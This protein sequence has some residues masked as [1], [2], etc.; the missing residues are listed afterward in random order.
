MKKNYIYEI[1]IQ[2]DGETYVGQRKCKCEISQDNYLGSG[3]ILKNAKEKYGKENFKKVILEEL[4]DDAPLSLSNE[5][6]IYWIAKRKSEGKAEY[7][8]SGGGQACSNP[9]RI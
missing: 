2:I 9:F 4:P 7:N 8:I 1:V 6:E 5:R 3:S